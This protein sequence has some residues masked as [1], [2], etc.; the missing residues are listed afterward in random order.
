MLDDIVESALYT[1]VKELV[2]REIQDVLDKRLDNC[3]HGS[4][5]QM[6]VFY[7]DWNDW[8]AELILEARDAAL[9]SACRNF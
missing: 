9:S 7:S 4:V 6:I 5:P 2:S 8:H 1:E 3:F